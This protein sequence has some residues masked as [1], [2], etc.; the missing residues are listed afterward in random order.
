[1]GFL[2][3]LVSAAVKV[4]LTP[5]AV[6]KDA[7]SIAVGDTPDATKDLLKDAKNDVGDAFNDLGDGEIL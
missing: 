3:G 6:V 1:M 4:V 7:A 2:T 5:V